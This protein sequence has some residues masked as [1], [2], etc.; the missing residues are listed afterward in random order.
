MQDETLAIFATNVAIEQL[1]FVCWSERG[2][3]QCLCLTASEQRRSV[4]TGHDA[5]FA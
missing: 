1:C 3:R 4:R 2:Q 5:D